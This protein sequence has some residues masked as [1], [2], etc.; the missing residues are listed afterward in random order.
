MD[1]CNFFIKLIKKLLWTLQIFKKNSNLNFFNNHS[2]LTAVLQYFFIT[3]FLKN[4][5]NE[6]ISK[7]NFASK[8]IK[9]FLQRQT[10]SSWGLLTWFDEI[11]YHH[12]FLQFNVKSGASAK[13]DGTLN[14]NK[15]LLSKANKTPTIYNGASQKLPQALQV[16]TQN[17]MLLP[18]YVEV[19]EDW[20]IQ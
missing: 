18:I 15:Q 2:T 4:S 14:T 9:I 10:N 19:S 13:S 11:L 7:K 17:I 12:S 5:Q 6:I 8:C 1:N 16:L 3:N 20:T